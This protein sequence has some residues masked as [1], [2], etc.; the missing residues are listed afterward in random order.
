MIDIK[1]KSKYDL[2]LNNSIGF[3]K[4]PKIFAKWFTG[5]VK[6]YEGRLIEYSSV[7]YGLINEINNYL[8]FKKGVLINKRS[9]INKPIIY[10]DP[11]EDLPF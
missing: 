2:G 9:V 10:V 3:A 6:T 8:K 5:E 4:Q 1:C 7:Y 11:E